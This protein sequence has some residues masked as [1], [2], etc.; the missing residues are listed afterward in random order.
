MLRDSTSLHIE[1]ACE[2]L[3]QGGLVVMPTETVYGL[4]ADATN[5]DAI[6]KIYTLKNRPRFNPLIVHV[7]S[8]EMAQSIAVCNSQAQ[9]LMMAL[10]PGPL[11]VIL[12]LRMNHGLSPLVTA[13]L[14]TVAVR[15]PAHPVAQALIR[16]TKRPLAAPS[17]NPSGRLSPT[18]AL[19]VARYFDQEALFILAGG[20]SKVGIESTILDLGENV[21][22]ILRAGAIGVDELEPLI[23]HVVFADGGEAIKAP[24]QLKRH[25]ATNTP[26]RL[27]AVDVQKGEAFLGFGNMNFIGAKG[28]GF[29]R[30]MPHGL[31]RNLSPEGDLHVAAT[32]LYAMLDELDHVGVT[33]IAV[34]K[35]PNQGL[36]I[37]INDRLT[38]AAIRED[39]K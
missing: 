24:G 28:F 18:Q 36:G 32:H 20:T 11:T 25:Y 7:E 21:P 35:I 15:M 4:A 3:L 26:L 17:A 13:G 5:S 29:V 16:G 1:L 39:E 30:D 8:I 22:K 31:W 27:N 19:Q 33:C 9:S 10:W 6:E 12:P 2:R 23:G 37:A 14:D 38:R 34:Q